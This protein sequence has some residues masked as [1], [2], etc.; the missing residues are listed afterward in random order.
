MQL[1]LF[2]ENIY[3][4]RT[5]FFRPRMARRFVIF[6][7]FGIISFLFGMDGT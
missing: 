6:Y 4:L 7:F 1:F 3:I 2:F 5:R